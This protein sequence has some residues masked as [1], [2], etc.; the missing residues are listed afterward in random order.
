[1]QVGGAGGSATITT[2]VRGC[3]ACGQDHGD[4]EF[5][6]I[7]RPVIIRGNVFTHVAACRIT[8]EP[9]FLRRRGDGYTTEG[10]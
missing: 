10:E 6:P 7:P 8:N 2:D 1:M 9:V 5:L 4:M 3:S